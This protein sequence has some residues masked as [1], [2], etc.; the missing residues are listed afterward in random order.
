MA[1]QRVQELKQTLDALL[2]DAALNDLS[3]DERLLAE[4]A[5]RNFTSG[6]AALL[7]AATDFM[8]AY[9]EDTV[10]EFTPAERSAYGLPELK[11]G[12]DIW[13]EVEFRHPPEV[14]LGGGPLKPGQSYISFEGEVSWEREHG[15]QLVFD[16][17]SHVCKVGPYDGHLTNAHAYGN[18]ALLGVIYK[19]HSLRD[20]EQQPV[21][22]QTTRWWW[23]RRK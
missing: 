19:G 9:Y 17:G 15:L 21:G 7:D 6:G 20:E 1:S 11:D 4:D 18:P 8:R 5:A 22:G 23:F 13:D 10:G 3:P 2:G 16:H 12:A 14:R